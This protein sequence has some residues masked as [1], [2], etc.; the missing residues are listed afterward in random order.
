[1]T[2]LTGA[3]SEEDDNGHKTHEAKCP[4]EFIG[5]K[6]DCAVGG[7]QQLQTT[8]PSSRHIGCPTLKNPQL[9]DSNKNLVLGP[10]W[11]LD[12]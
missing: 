9:S 12:T 5:A 2:K 7:Q 4:L 3:E 6:C 1:M 10:G 11:M 8:E